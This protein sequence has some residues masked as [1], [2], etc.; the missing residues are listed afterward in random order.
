MDVTQ[1]EAKLKEYGQEHLLQ[2]WSSLTEEERHHLFRDL[3]E[4]ISLFNVSVDQSNF[5]IIV[6]FTELT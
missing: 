1:L 6:C 2:F 5:S 4:Y 3:N